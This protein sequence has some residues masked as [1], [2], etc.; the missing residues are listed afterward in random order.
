MCTSDR[1]NNLSGVKSGKDNF[2]FDE[3]PTS[4]S[5]IYYETFV[6]LNCYA[7]QKFLEILIKLQIPRKMQIIIKI[8][9]SPTQFPLICLK[10]HTFESFEQRHFYILCFI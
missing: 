6:Q 7:S 2:L 1:S 9:Q 3:L 4:F 8:E 5:E 10:L